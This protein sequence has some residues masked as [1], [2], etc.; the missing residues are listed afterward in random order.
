MNESRRQTTST[1]FSS[2]H[3]HV[4]VA[5]MKRAML[6]CDVTCGAADAS[7]KYSTDPNKKRIG[8]CLFPFTT[9]PALLHTRIT[10]ICTL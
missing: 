4:N 9:Q 5:H 1:A 6:C 2:Y 3:H 8:S 10:Y 7:S